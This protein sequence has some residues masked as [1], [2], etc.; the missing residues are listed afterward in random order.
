MLEL[1]D[2]YGSRP[3]MLKDIATRQE[4]SEKYLSKLII[5][6]RQAELVKSVRGAHGGYILARV[7][8]AIN[9]NEIIM[10]LEGNIA[11]VDCTADSSICGRS[12]RC[13]TRDVWCELN[14][15]ITTYLSGISLEDVLQEH[16]GR[17]GRDGNL[18][19]I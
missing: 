4:L 6:L 10:V 15:T 12:S 5:P 8:A 16:R 13:P 17:A 14:S 18:Y 11:I 7:P 3:I 9:L 19:V 2:G 1:A